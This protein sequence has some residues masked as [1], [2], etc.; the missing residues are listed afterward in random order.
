MLNNLKLGSRS[1]LR[2]ST[3]AIALTF[4]A[5][6]LLASCDQR[7]VTYEERFRPAYHF[8]PARN[9]MNDPNGLV[10]HN[11]EYHLFFQHNPRGNRWG[12]LSWGHAVSR[13][14]VNW[15]ELGVAMPERDVM[16]F[17]GSAVIDAANT[18]GFAS[19]RTPPM[20]AFYTGHD[21]DDGRES[22]Y[23]AYSQDEGRTWTQYDG[24]PI[25]EAPGISQF[26][27]P[28]VF[29]HEGTQ[30]W[31]MV[32]VHSGEQRV[33]IY[34]SQNMRAWREVSVFGPGGQTGGPWETPDLFE[35]PVEG[36]GSRWVLS[37]GVTGQ[38]GLSAGSGVQ[39]FVGGFDGE[40]FVAD[41]GAPVG[42]VRWV[43]YGS[44]FY[45]PQTWSG[46]PAED[47]RRIWI[48]WM[49]NTRHA[50]DIPTSPWRGMMTIP[51]ELS[52]ALRDGRY[53]LVQ[54][55][56]RELQTLR[57]DAVTQ[58]AVTIVRGERALAE[59]AALGGA[60]ELEIAFRPATSGE[61]GLVLSYGA[62]TR[63]R[64]GYDARNNHAFVDRSEGGAFERDSF[65]ARHYMPVRLSDGMLRLRIFLDHSSVEV[66]ADDGARVISD[67]IF[68]DGQLRSVS[69]YTTG[70]GGALSSL[71]A[72]RMAAMDRN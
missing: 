47:G 35:L 42:V 64:I 68:A 1:G 48:A 33:A 4:A 16:I 60:M 13:D 32:L 27:D 7:A 25:I 12:H 43:D 40:R 53:E 62:A 39:Y 70:E 41:D 20:V 30:R 63:L 9:W 18:S 22:Q 38:A 51:R 44:D 49:A 8:T 5:V 59:V 36:G 15:R 45:A 56:V 46:I 57:R 6:G 14:L 50:E 17:S 31:V 19:S 72:W 34:T 3:M 66:F 21:P 28:K 69:L 55:P 71:N 52:L 37:V 23:L 24:N 58:E 65:R 10:F 26:R 29:W 67:A 61:T 2:L 11:G 54:R